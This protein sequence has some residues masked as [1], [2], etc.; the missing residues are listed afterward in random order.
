MTTVPWT[1]ISANQK[2][3]FMDPRMSCTHAPY[4]MKMIEIVI[5]KEF[6]KEMKPEPYSL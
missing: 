5:N 1:S 4:L 3:T 2:F 6:K